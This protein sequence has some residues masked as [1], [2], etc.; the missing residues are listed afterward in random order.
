MTEL[1]QSNRAT[2]TQA[3]ELL[4]K[5]AA[6]LRRQQAIT[7]KHRRA[8]EAAIR[9]LE[10]LPDET[11]AEKDIALLRAVVSSERSSSFYDPAFINSRQAATI[12][13]VSHQRVCQLLAMDR[14]KGA[15][16]DGPYWRIPQQPEIVPSVPNRWAQMPKG[17]VHASQAA[18][19]LGV[20]SSMVRAYIRQGR[21]AGA[22]TMGKNK[23]IMP[24]PVQILP[25]TKKPRRSKQAA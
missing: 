25:K 20:T 19:E 7:A 11:L 14:V 5:L 21:I 9:R 16:K 23:W 2:R 12:L 22:V 6:E 24:T 17:Y 4:K 8:T 18:K 10:A 15:W 13:G 1:K 3:V